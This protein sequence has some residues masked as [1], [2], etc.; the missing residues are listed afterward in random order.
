MKIEVDV[1]KL[2]AK[3][4]SV[5]LS[6]RMIYTMLLRSTS[7]LPICLSRG[8]LEKCIADIVLWS[9]VYSK[10]RGFDLEYYLN[11]VVKEYMEKLGQKT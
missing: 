5:G 11:K 1:E 4:G 9:M 7:E 8:L 10:V 6:E 3:I 2:L